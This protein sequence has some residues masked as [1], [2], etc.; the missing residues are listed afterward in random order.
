MEATCCAENQVVG[1]GAEGKSEDFAV[2]LNEADAE[3]KLP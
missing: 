1:E 2:Q 3:P